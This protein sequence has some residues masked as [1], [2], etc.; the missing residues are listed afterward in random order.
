MIRS[1]LR[2]ISNSNSP[3][4]NEWGSQAGNKR[5]IAGYTVSN[6]SMIM[7]IN[8]TK[9][10]FTMKDSYFAVKQKGSIIVEFIPLIEHDQNSQ[11]KFLSNKD[12]KT[13]LFNSDKI[14]DF[15]TEKP[16]MIEYRK[17]REGVSHK[18]EIKKNSPNWEWSLQ[19]TGNQNDHRKV[20]VR[21]SDHFFIGKLFDF[22]I[23]YIYGWY[24]LGDSRL[25]EQ[26]VAVEVEPKDP[27]NNI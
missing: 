16:V 14:C 26:S 3:F 8:I 6:D 11:K 27:F 19:V 4:S 12:K 23:P 13:I 1:L 20:V 18:L 21:P 22:S 24:A 10:K 5:V 2:A 7:S 25:A 15:L 17:E 9:A